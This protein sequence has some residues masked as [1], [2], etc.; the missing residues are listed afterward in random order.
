MHEEFNHRSLSD[1]MFTRCFVLEN[2]LYSGLLAGREFPEDCAASYRSA[3]MRS[4]EGKVSLQQTE[5]TNFL[6]KEIIRKYFK[7]GVKY[8]Y[9]R[10]LFYF[11]L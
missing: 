6:R 7:E 11:L 9:L 4:G 5:P 10:K 1:I 3:T 8:G 2:S